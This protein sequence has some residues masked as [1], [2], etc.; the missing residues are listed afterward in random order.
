MILADAGWREVLAVT[1]D[2]SDL[3]ARALIPHVD[4]GSFATVMAC[5][6]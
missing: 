2:G 5:D 1:F 3:T 6:D 4:R